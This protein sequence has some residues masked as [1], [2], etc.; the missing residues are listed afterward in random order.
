MSDL[1]PLKGHEVGN[2]FKIAERLNHLL[3]LFRVGHR[4]DGTIDASMIPAGTAKVGQKGDPGPQGQKGDK[5]DLGP[6]GPQGIAGAKG[7][8]GDPGQAGAKG[9]KGDIGPQGPAGRDAEQR[10]VAYINPANATLGDVV[11][12]LVKAGFMQPPPAT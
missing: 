10:V 4:P 5:G 11:A 12:A 8:P 6:T 2:P 9:D 7:D 1:T 3:E